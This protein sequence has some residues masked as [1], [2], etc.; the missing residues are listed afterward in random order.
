[1][2]V[3]SVLEVC[4]GGCWSVFGSVV[5]SLLQRSQITILVVFSS[6]VMPDRVAN[7]M[8]GAMREKGLKANGLTMGEFQST[9]L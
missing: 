2:V 3:L 7:S 4:V 1:M 9:V 5:L 8:L 6:Y